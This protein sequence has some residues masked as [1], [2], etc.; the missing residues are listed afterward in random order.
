MLKKSN[1]IVV[2][3]ISLRCLNHRDGIE[4]P[5]ILYI[6][7][8]PLLL[9]VVQRYDHEFAKGVSGVLTIST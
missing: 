3:G 4:Q 6:T 8:F 9:D 2:K 7:L 1:K 5:S